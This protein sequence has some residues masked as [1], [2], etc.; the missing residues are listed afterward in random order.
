MSYKTSESVQARTDFERC[1]HTS[2]RDFYDGF[3]TVLFQK[4]CIDPL[5][6]DDYLHQKY[7]TYEDRGLS[8]QGFI[9]EQY[10]EEACEVLDQLI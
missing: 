8:M 6:F 5:L 2:I 3:T 9:R 1:F 10:G 4:I 7:G